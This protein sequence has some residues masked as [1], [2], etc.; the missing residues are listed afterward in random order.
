VEIIDVTET[1]FMV[2]VGELLGAQVESED[3]LYLLIRW[4]KVLFKVRKVRVLGRINEIRRL[5]GR[6]DC[7]LSDD[8]GS[9]I[10]RVWE[11]KLHL[12]E[13]VREGDIVE[14]FAYPRVWEGEIY[15]SPIIIARR[16]EQ[17]LERR[18]REIA[19]VREFLYKLTAKDEDNR[20][21]RMKGMK[22]HAAPQKS[23]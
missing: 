4:D 3:R 8:S 5:S 23:E 7:L 1:F 22:S 16:S 19:E 21:T 9:V 12:L 14:V 2:K 17:A 20:L 10:V 15:L 11:E 18:E 6:S 13:E